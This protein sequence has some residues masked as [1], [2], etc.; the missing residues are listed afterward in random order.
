VTLT[1]ADVTRTSHYQAVCHGVCE[2]ED[3]G[4]LNVDV[5]VRWWCEA[6]RTRGRTS[7]VRG[8]ISSRD[9]PVHVRGTIAGSAGRTRPRKSHCLVRCRPLEAEYRKT[10]RI[11]LRSKE[12]GAK[13]GH[14][15]QD[16]ASH[17]PRWNF[18]IKHI[19]FQTSH[20]SSH[21]IWLCQP[22]ESARCTYKGGCESYLRPGTYHLRAGSGR[23]LHRREYGRFLKWLGNVYFASIPPAV[24]STSG[25]IGY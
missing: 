12:S 9:I 17:I 16:C 14:K 2:D 15:K 24:G 11:V 6:S 1:P 5:L 13:Q 25:Q 20:E 3:N 22:H 21:N 7:P 8:D 4:L 18:V 10:K 19:G 23:K